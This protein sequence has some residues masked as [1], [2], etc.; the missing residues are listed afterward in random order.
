MLCNTDSCKRCINNKYAT[1]ENN[2]PLIGIRNSKK[3]NAKI[4]DNNTTEKF[5]ISNWNLNTFGWVVLKSSMIMGDKYDESLAR[6]KIVESED[7]YW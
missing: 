5:D 6:I 2:G 3:S 7:I 1:N 4:N